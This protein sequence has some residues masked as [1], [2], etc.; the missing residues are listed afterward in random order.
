MKNGTVIKFMGAILT[1]D[2]TLKK[3][4]NDPFFVNQAKIANAKLKDKK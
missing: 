1:V 3:Y 4:A 2:N